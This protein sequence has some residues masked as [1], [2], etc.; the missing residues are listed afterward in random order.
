MEGV[1][2]EEEEILLIAEPNLLTVRTIALQE[3]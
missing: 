1:T 2:Y 3:L